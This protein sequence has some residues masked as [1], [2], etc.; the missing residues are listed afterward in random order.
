MVQ[1]KKPQLHLKIK[2]VFKT[3]L[4]V[5]KYIVKRGIWFN[6][7]LDFNRKFYNM[8]ITG[9]ID[10]VVQKLTIDPHYIHMRN[11]YG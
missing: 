8:I 9:D 10:G 1:I 2:R 5:T 3:I 4:F 11:Q 7:P 6:F